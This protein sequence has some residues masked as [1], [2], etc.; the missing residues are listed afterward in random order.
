MWKPL[1]IVAIRYHLKVSID[2]GADND[3]D[4]KEPWQGLECGEPTANEAGAQAQH[5]NTG[6]RASPRQDACRRATKG[7][8]GKHFSGADKP[9]PVWNEKKVG[10]YG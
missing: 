5:A 2:K 8:S 1:R 7:V 6:S 4:T 10:W 3:Q 9:E